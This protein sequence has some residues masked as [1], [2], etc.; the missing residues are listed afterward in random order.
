VIIST[1]TETQQIEILDEIP[2]NIVSSSTADLPNLAASDLPLDRAISDNIM[3]P[4][5]NPDIT[6][7]SSTTGAD[8][9]HTHSH[10]DSSAAITRERLLQV[11]G[12]NVDTTTTTTSTTTTTTSTS[13]SAK[14]K[15]RYD[16]EAAGCTVVVRPV[17]LEDTPGVFK[18]IDT[19]R[20]HLERWLPQMRGAFT[21]LREVRHNVDYWLWKMQSARGLVLAVEVDGSIE[22][23]IAI[24][25]IDWTT[26]CAYLGY[27]LTKGAQGKG[28]ATRGLEHVVKIAFEELQL[29]HLDISTMKENTKSKKLA[30]RLGFE[31]NPIIRDL[32]TQYLWGV[33]PVRQV[34]LDVFTCSRTGAETK[35]E[36]ARKPYFWYNLRKHIQENR[37]PIS[38][39]LR[40]RQ[41]IPPS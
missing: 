37:D 23:I 11:I 10:T 31:P 40:S 41:L 20:E 7:A 34:N 35:A 12:D 19:N 13:T 8:S 36:D 14:N 16:F 38:I 30:Y 32:D 1:P 15:F 5:H 22:G 25:I 21:S 28:I 6:T 17:E 2:P 4:P 33:L 29:D 39:D 3:Q 27:W 26:K 9:T 18:A 24:N